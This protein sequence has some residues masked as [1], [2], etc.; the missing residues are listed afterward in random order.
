M[1]TQ[2][3]CLIVFYD[4]SYACKLILKCDNCLMTRYEGEE[5]EWVDSPPTPPLTP[6]TP[7]V[8]IASDLE[9]RPSKRKGLRILGAA[10]IFWAAGIG[11]G[12][13]IQHSHVIRDRGH[14]AVE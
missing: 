1:S 14:V 2:N 7:T 8:E 9:A 13:I 10:A 4:F 6:D 5:F 11:V 3:L 12:E